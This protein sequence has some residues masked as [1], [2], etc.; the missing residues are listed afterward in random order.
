MLL[1]KAIHNGAVINTLYWRNQS[2]GQQAEFVERE[3]NAILFQC[4]NCMKS[5]L[6]LDRVALERSKERTQIKLIISN[7]MYPKLL[8]QLFILPTSL[9][10]SMQILSVFTFFSPK[11]ILSINLSTS[12]WRCFIQTNLALALVLDEKIL[13]DSSAWIP[14][15]LVACMQHTTGFLV[16]RALH[17]GKRFGSTT[18]GR[19][20]WR[21][22]TRA[23]V[24]SAIVRCHDVNLL[25]V[26][27]GYSGFLAF[28][29]DNRPRLF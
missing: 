1:H 3:A 15:H 20:N 5:I 24:Q 10:P 28:T 6:V 12:H 29:N 18:V 16:A 19:K 9:I 23:F 26:L 17:E 2:E 25:P 13:R 11:P 4:A 27:A 21:L 8:C 7:L 22:C 14:K